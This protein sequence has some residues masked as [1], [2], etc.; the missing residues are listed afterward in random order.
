MKQINLKYVKVELG[1]ALQHIN[2]SLKYFVYF[3]KNETMKK[4]LF[5]LLIGGM[6]LFSCEKEKQSQCETDQTFKLVFMNY[7][8]S[9]DYGY[10][11][12]LIVNNEKIDVE[13]SFDELILN[14]PVGGSVCVILR[15]DQT[16]IYSCMEAKPSPCA[17]YNYFW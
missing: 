15:K 10:I 13:Y 5:L 8:M 16:K 1:V 11:K 14:V 3:R 9:G 17:T 4:L 2:D 6:F 7:K 12:Y